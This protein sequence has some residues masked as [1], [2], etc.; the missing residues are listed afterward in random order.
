MAGIRIYRS[1]VFLS[2]RS[3]SHAQSS[4]A[5]SPVGYSLVLLSSSHLRFADH[6]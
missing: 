1:D 6:L 5:M 3:R 4:F 2:E